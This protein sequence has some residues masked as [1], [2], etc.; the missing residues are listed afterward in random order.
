MEL[1]LKDSKDKSRLKEQNVNTKI[2]N[3]L[4]KPSWPIKMIQ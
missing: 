2:I 4:I 3:S 1:S